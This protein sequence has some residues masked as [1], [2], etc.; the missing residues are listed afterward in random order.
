MRVLVVVDYP[1]VAEISCVMHRILGHDANPATSGFEALARARDFDPDIVI[2]DI[3]LPDRNGYEV[4]RALRDQPRGNALHIAVLTG[5]NQPED[6]SHAQA[7]GVDQHFVKPAC[8][9]KFQQILDAGKAKRF[10]PTAP[11]A[12]LAAVV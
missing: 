12:A 6:R 4:A 8:T 11:A 3:G 2:L 9:T 10:P 7:A 5:W 1:G